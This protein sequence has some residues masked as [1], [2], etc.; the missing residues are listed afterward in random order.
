MRKWWAKLTGLM[1][2]AFLL[3]PEMAAAAG[4]GCTPGNGS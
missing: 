4:R 2:M 1:V 3:L